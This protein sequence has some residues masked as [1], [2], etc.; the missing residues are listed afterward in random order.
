MPPAYDKHKLNF[1]EGTEIVKQAAGEE[2]AAE[3]LPLFAKAY[4]QRNPV[5]ILTLDFLFRL[6]AQ[7]FIRQRSAGNG[8]TYSYLF[9]QDMPI[10]GGNVPWHCADVPYVFHNTELV[11][12]TQEEG[13]T[14]KLEAQIFDSVIAFARTGNPNHAGIP[15]WPA[16]TPAEEQTMIFCKDTKVRCNHDAEL[17]PL[18]AKYMGPVFERMMSE[19]M[20]EV[21][22]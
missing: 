15:E 6:P 13:V 3:L 12:S 19:N 16:S 2:A 11:P 4:P 18:L 5:E 9:D 20:G 21:Q 14:E 1:E 7:Q 22:H 10:N 17:I 8:C